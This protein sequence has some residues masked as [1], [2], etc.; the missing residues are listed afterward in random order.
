MK[1]LGLSLLLVIIIVATSIAMFACSDIT[2]SI[3]YNDTI[4][5]KFGDAIIDLASVDAPNGATEFVNE[6]RITRK[7]LI[8]GRIKG[9]HLLGLYAPIGEQIEVTIDAAEISNGHSIEFNKNCSLSEIPF[10]L[11]ISAVNTTFSR[12]LAGGMLE[13]NVAEECADTFELTIKGAIALP[14]YRY[15]I[16]E[17]IDQRRVGNYAVL[18]CTNVRIYQTTNR[19]STISEPKKV[20]NW[21]R[22]AVTFMD[23]LLGLSFWDNDYS[24]MCIYIRESSDTYSIDAEKNCLYLSTAY[25]QS[26]VAWDS[27]YSDAYYWNDDASVY[28]VLKH[29]AELKI[30]RSNAFQ[31]TYLKNYIV[32]ILAQLTYID[33]VDSAYALNNGSVENNHYIT[34]AKNT[35]LIIASEF[36]SDSQRY[37]ALFTHIYYN[38]SREVALEVLKEIKENKISEA[39]TIAYLAN[40]QKLNLITLA[41]KLEISLYGND[42][43]KMQE[44]D[45]YSICA[46]KEAFGRVANGRQTGTHVRIGEKKIFDFDSQIISDEEYHVD[47]VNGAEGAWNKLEDGTYEYTPSADKLKDTFVLTLKSGDKEIKLLG[48]ISV[49]IAVSEYKLYKNMTATTLNDAIKQSKDMTP[50]KVEAHIKADISQETETSSSTSFAVAHGAIQVRET[51][52]YTIYLKSAGLC[53]VL[54]GVEEYSSEIFNNFL[55]VPDYTSELSYTAKLEKGYKYIYTIYNLA[56]QG[57]G[58]AQLGIKY[59]NNAIEDIDTKY[60]VYPKLERSNIVSYETPQYYIEAIAKQADEY[61]AA[62]V[63]NIAQFVNIAEYK[64]GTDS[65]LIEKDSKVSFVLPLKQTDTVN[66]IRMDVQD[67]KDVVVTIY[68]GVMHKAVLATATLENGVNIIPCE[69]RNLD[70]IKLEFTSKDNYKLHIDVLEAGDRIN[71]MTIIPSSSTYIEYIAEWGTS[72]EY[73]AINGKLAVSNSKDSELSY[74]FN[75]NEISIYAT[76]GPNFGT[77]KIVIDGQNKGLIDLNNIKVQCAQ[78]VFNAKLKDGDHTI[79]ISAIDETPIN[80]DYLAVASLGETKQTND[81]SKLWYVAIIPGILLIVGIV[82]IS[83]DAKEKKKRAIAQQH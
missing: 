59:G 15:G 41:N 11:P 34:D 29:I 74:S 76:K 44:Y 12:T 4:E 61:N 28:S 23:E 58:Y 78:L 50:V 54:F 32:D 47:S 45:A 7:F 16:D 19:I 5:S 1:K 46:N 36:S 75:G 57:V 8:D 56:N 24:P 39:V 80:I 53:S 6:K 62:E 42:I 72:K 55:T 70:S 49:D 73:I 38:F 63:A 10:S 21:W 83:L 33:M 9:A 52:Y 60:L 31:D 81:Y 35:D 2:Q 77:A 27:I 43:E 18:D 48:G 71:A 14:Y 40:A 20:M 79:R 17:S 26:C 22:N 13:L 82:F 51:A 30:A 64:L 66:Y 65:E 37:N 25:D 67:M 3:S 68:G 69:E